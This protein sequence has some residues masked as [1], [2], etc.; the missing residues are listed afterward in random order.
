MK[1]AHKI[2]EEFHDHFRS[3]ERIWQ[4]TNEWFGFK[5]HQLQW[6]HDKGYTFEKINLEEGDLVLC[7]SPIF[8]GG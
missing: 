7:E 1:G 5:E 2:S 3:E 8:Q 4:W 6:L